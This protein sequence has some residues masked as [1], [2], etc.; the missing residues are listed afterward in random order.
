M[1]SV[2]KYLS[3][4]NRN[5]SMKFMKIKGNLGIVYNLDFKFVSSETRWFRDITNSHIN[6]D[7]NA[8]IIYS[9]D[10]NHSFQYR[11]LWKEIRIIIGQLG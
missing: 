8:Q 6:S 1:R 7:I 11:E 3:D 4:H 5:F 2:P 10:K 9:V